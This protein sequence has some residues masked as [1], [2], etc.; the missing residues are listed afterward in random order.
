MLLGR[1]GYN[2]IVIERLNIRLAEWLD[3]QFGG[4]VRLSVL[5]SGYTISVV[6]LSVLQSGYSIIVA[7]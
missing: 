4:V 7:E 1:S 5:Q 3:Y 2:T 6:I